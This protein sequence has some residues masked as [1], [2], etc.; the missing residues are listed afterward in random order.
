MATPT[1]RHVTPAFRVYCGEDALASLQREAARHRTQRVVVLCGGSIRREAHALERV[2]DALGDLLVGIFDDVQQHSPLPTVLAAAGMLLDSEADGIVAV[3]GG[4]AVVT[5]RAASIVLAEQRDV[6]ELCTRRDDNGRLVSPRLDA[7]KIPQWVVPSTPTTAYAKA[8]SAV[9]DP[10]TGERLAMYDPK[11]RTKALFI[12]PAMANTAPVG[13]ASA[14]ALNALS[15]AVE[16]LQAATDDVLAHA[17]LA[18]ALKTLVSGLPALRQ[19]PHEAGPRMQLMLGALLSGQG[20]DHVGG[21]LAQA[22]SHAAGPRSSASNGTVEAMLL[23]HAVRFNAPVTGGRLDSIIE[24]LGQA[25]PLHGSP[26]ERVTAGIDRLLR[27]L[28]VPSRLRDVD[29]P[30]EALDEIVEHALDDWAITRVPRPVD[31]P[32]LRGLLSQAW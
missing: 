25:V 11:T 1:F 20:S 17:L 22:L 29:I 2:T 7:H 31:R 13:L 10:D 4:S 30:E 16:G 9:R 19:N 5:A 3:G 24:A 18:Q 15:M 23:P 12:D 26:A 27:D 21:G 14:S 8:G 32:S 28:D 6:R